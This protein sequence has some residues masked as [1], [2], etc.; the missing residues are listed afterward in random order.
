LDHVHAG[1]VCRKSNLLLTDSE[2]WSFRHPP[3]EREIEILIQIADGVSSIRQQWKFLNRSYRT[4]FTT[5]SG[6]VL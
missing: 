5:P 6:V 2:K 4:S 3:E 1:T